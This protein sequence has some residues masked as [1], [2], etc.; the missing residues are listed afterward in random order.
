[1]ANKSINWSISLRPTKLKD[2]YGLDKLKT[3]AYKAAK[4]NEWPEA[5]LLRQ[6][7]VQVKQQPQRFWH[8]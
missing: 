2:V 7:T 1:M 6:S 3:F 8:R 5:M 4:K